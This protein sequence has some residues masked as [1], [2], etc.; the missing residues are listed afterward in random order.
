MKATTRKKTCSSPLDSSH[1]ASP[2]HALPTTASWYVRPLV[3]SQS[4]S[5]THTSTR[6]QPMRS[7]AGAPVGAIGLNLGSS[8]PSAAPGHANAHNIAVTAAAP[9]TSPSIAVLPPKTA[10]SILG[11]TSSAEDDA[12]TSMSCTMLPPALSP[13]TKTR[14]ASPC[15]ASHPSCADAAHWSAAQQSS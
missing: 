11:A 10:P 2:R 4:I 1:A 14:D 6:S 15:S 9:S 3:A 13:A 8:A 12:R 7:S 5:A